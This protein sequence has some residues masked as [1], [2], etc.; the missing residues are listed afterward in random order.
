MNSNHDH[1]LDY[2]YEFLVVELDRSSGVL[3]VTLDRPEVRN[4]LNGELVDELCDAI[5]WSD[6]D[7]RVRVVLLRGAGKDFCAGADL[8]ALLE[9][10][11]DPTIDIWLPDPEPHP[12]VE[13][14]TWREKTDSGP[15]ITKEYHTPAG[16]L[17]QTVRETRDWCSADHGFGAMTT[18]GIETRDD[19]TKMLV[20][21]VVRQD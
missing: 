15:L 13:I 16:V 7:E 21:G 17:R 14:K 9:L 3:T 18:F 6:A 2:D 1:M 5:G 19:G 4:A 8:Q 10:G 12:D 11:C 20:V